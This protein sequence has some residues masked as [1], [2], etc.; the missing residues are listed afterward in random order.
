MRLEK[1]T[2]VFKFTQTSLGLLNC[3]MFFIKYTP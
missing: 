3:D 1:I 2:N